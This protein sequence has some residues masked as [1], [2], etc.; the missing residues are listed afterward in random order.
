MVFH[1]EHTVSHRTLNN[2][3]GEHIRMARELEELGYGALWFGEPG[4]VDPQ[5]VLECDIPSF[6]GDR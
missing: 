3:R 2:P 4:K 1:R 5:F 6:G